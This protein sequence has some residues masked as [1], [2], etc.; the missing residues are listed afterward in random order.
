MRRPW[1][2][3][4]AAATL[5]AG[6]NQYRTVP[7]SEAS[8]FSKENFPTKGGVVVRDVDGNHVR[9]EHF[10]QLRAKGLAC[11]LS[12]VHSQPSKPCRHRWVE[13]VPPVGIEI[14]GTTLFLHPSPTR[15]RQRP[16][17]RVDE[18]SEVVVSA[19]S[20]RRGGIV[21]GTAVGVGMVVI[22]GGLGIMAL[23]ADRNTEDHSGATSLGIFIAG[24]AVGAATLLI[25][26]P[27]TTDLGDEIDP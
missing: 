12:D 6:C 25:T 26:M 24:A 9:I 16:S 1:L 20:G 21:I 19:K 4:L 10:R 7:V 5:V 17:V 27:L 23:S 13:V 14:H 8:K 11:I 2:I 15:R 22:G 3:A 18:V